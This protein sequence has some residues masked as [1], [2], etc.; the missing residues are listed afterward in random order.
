MPRFT[1]VLGAVQDACLARRSALLQQDFRRFE[2]CRHL[3]SGRQMQIVGKHDP[4]I[5]F[6]KAT[7]GIV[8][9]GDAG[10]IKIIARI[11]ISGRVAHVEKG[12]AMSGD[13]RCSE[14]ETHDGNHGPGG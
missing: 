2:Q 11:K 9:K 6:V 7:E 12:P 4:V 3:I 14:L 1:H 5:A 13:D 10:S 8:A